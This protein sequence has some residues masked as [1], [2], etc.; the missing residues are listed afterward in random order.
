MSL[1]GM[2]RVGTEERRGDQVRVT[3]HVPTSTE[4]TD[5]VL[6]FWG[7]TENISAGGLCVL[8]EGT[9]PPGT[10]VRLTLRS[11][12]R[13]VLN[14]LGT[15]IR[16]QPLRDAGAH[17]VGIAFRKPLSAAIIANLAAGRY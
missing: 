14:V 1:G 2:D 11:R 16:V 9:L 7:H 13:L 10:G 15:V 17:R 8:Q 3:L 5:A 6:S 4:P 12:R